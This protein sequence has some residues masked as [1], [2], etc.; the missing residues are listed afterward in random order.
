MVVKGK[1][2]EGVSVTTFPHFAVKN[3]LLDQVVKKGELI[4]EQFLVPKCCV[5]KVLYSAHSYQLGKHLGVEKTYNR[6]LGHFWPG[7]VQDYCKN[8][9][10]CQ[11]S[12]LKVNR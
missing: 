8:C 9:M 11:K 3:G 10:K 1:R 2:V 4:I 7:M 6:I 12:A 5:L